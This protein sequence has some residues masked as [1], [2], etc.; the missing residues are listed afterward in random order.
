MRTIN[1]SQLAAALRDYY[2]VEDEPP[3]NDTCIGK[4]ISD[5]ES[6]DGDEWEFDLDDIPGYNSVDEDLSDAEFERL[7]DAH[8]IQRQKELERQIRSGT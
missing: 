1:A 5:L 7:V 6:E 8:E 2:A 4:I 3:Q